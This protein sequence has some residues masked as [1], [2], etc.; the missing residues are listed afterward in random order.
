MDK[1]ILKS[2]KDILVSGDKTGKIQVFVLVILIGVLLVMFA[3][4]L[5]N[6]VVPT[7]VT[8]DQDAG[9]TLQTD[10]REDIEMESI[11]SQIDGVGSVK[12]MITYKNTG[13]NIYATDV[14]ETVDYE[15]QLSGDTKVVTRKNEDKKATVV[16]NGQ[17]SPIYEDTMTADVKGVLVVAEGA[18]N[19]EVCS[20]ILNAVKVLTGVEV[21]NIAICPYK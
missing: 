19:P 15:E 6:S 17:K 1:K 8:T 3:N 7:D 5:L 14:N 11:L 21:H 9:E 12:V 18:E 2:L 4:N 20:R 13:K 16:F 10:E